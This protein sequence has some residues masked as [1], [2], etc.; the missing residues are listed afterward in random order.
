MVDN[1]VGEDEV[2]DP[3]EKPVGE[4]HDEQDYCVEPSALFGCVDT[5]IFCGHPYLEHPE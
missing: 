4:P 3:V 5:A 2:N 1:A